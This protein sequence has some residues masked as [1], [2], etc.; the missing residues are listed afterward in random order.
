P[1]CPYDRRPS[2]QGVRQLRRGGPPLR[3]PDGSGGER[4]EWR[5]DRVG[6]QERTDERLVGGRD[7]E[8]GSRSRGSDIRQR[9]QAIDLVVA[10]VAAVISE[11][12]TSE[13]QSR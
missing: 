5:L 10:D 2:S 9:E 13:L 8:R 11:E 12:H 4:H 6:A 7:R 1:A 3:A